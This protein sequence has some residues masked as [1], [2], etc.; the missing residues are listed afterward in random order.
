MPEELP[1]TTSYDV[2]YWDCPCCGDYNDG[3]G[4]DSFNGEVETCVGCG[5]QV[6]VR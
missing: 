3:I 6:V 2:P 4:R 1:E 5:E